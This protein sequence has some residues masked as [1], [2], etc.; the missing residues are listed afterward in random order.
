MNAAQ[1]AYIE[2]LPETAR[3]WAILV[4]TEVVSPALGSHW[5]QHFPNTLTD[6]EAGAIRSA[7]AE[8]LELDGVELEGK[9]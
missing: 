6:T 2:R 1:R 7:L 9:P 5:S 3:D 8:L 4:W